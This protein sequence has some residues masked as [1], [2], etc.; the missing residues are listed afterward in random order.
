MVEKFK[1][2][3]RERGFKVEGNTV[4]VTQEARLRSL[5]ERVSIDDFRLYLT[6]CIE[7]EKNQQPLSPDETGVDP[8]F[9]EHMF[10]WLEEHIYRREE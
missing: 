6:Y 5:R 9:T 1:N 10:R 4:T 7:I 3:L 8:Q 2:W